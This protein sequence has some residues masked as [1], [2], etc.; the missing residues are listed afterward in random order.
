[1]KHV[2]IAD[3]ETLDRSDAPVEFRFD[4]KQILAAL[5]AGN[6][7]VC[8]AFVRRHA[9]RMLAVARRFLRCEQDAADA[10]QDAL[11][12]AFRSIKA[13]DGDAKPETWLHRIVVNACLM[14]LRSNRARPMASIEASHPELYEDPSHGSR[15]TRRVPSDELEARELR[16]RVRGCIDQLPE[17][18]RVVLLLRDIEQITTQETAIR[19]GITETCAKVRLHRAR[20]ALRS[21]LDPFLSN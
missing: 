17:P 13:F 15:A 14:K 2:A 3:R 16:A 11:L 6:P 18:Y 4:E 21:R 12:S 7:E 10:V 1:V 5:R 8:N 20:L 9:A 19:L